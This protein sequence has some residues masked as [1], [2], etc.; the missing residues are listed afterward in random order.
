MPRHAG[1]TPF[2]FSSSLGSVL[3][4]NAVLL[5]ME[6][7]VAS[8]EGLSAEELTKKLSF[9]LLGVDELENVV[10]LEHQC[11]FGAIPCDYS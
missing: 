8:V 2:V 4:R 11:N 6:E 7:A 5:K 10:C 1:G 9:S 3:L